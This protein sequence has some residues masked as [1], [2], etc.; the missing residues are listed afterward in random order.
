MTTRP[1][2]PWPR[3]PALLALPLLVLVLIAWLEWQP[4][5]GLLRAVTS[6]TD[7]GPTALG[8]VLVL[9]SISAFLAAI[10]VSAAEVL[11]AFRAG[12]GW[13]ARPYHLALAVGLLLVVLTGIGGLVADQ[14]PCWQGVPNCD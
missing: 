5:A 1:A 6:H 8:L 9:G 10:A 4:F 3:G 14:Y 12:R 2:D 13:T 7:G 11:R